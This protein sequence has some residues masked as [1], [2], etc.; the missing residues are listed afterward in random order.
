MNDETEIRD[1]AE[2][3]AVRDWLDDDDDGSPDRSEDV[4]ADGA[5]AA[6]DEQESSSEESGKST[7]EQ[8]P[9]SLS[10]MT[11]DEL[12]ARYRELE[13]ED[14]KSAFLSSID[15]IEKAKEILS[16]VTTTIVAAPEVA[17]GE[18]ETDW[19]G[20]WQQSAVAEMTKDL[21]VFAA[22]ALSDFKAGHLEVAPELRAEL[23]ENL[24]I[25]DSLPSGHSHSVAALERA[26]G[27]AQYAR[28]EQLANEP[29]VTIEATTSYQRPDGS[30]WLRE[31]DVRGKFRE[32]QVEG[33]LPPSEI[34]GQESKEGQSVDEIDTSKLTLEN[35]KGLSTQ[36]LVQLREKDPEG[37]ER[38]LQSASDEH[39]DAGRIASG[40]VR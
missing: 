23:E 31:T 16:T 1:D 10:E 39:E 24:A 29:M 35:V 36:Q 32:T 18:I 33:G 30:W 2:E 27:I 11:M 25:V 15:D 4:A 40:I 38:L 34:F 13:D 20:Y 19:R 7:E 8:E 6:A 37:W 22:Q 26:A 14:E 28:T 5:G 3:N 17:E 9:P 21:G 12:V